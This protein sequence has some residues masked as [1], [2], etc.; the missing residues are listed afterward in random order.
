MAF[1]HDFARQRT[2]EWIQ[3]LK[4][5]T[6]FSAVEPHA[7]YSYAENGHKKLTYLLR[8]MDLEAEVL[9]P[10]GSYLSQSFVP[11]AVG[12]PALSA[13]D[14]RVFTLPIRHGRMA[15]LDLVPISV[16]QRWQSRHISEPGPE[17]CR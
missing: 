14:F 4:V 16:Q 1:C 10:M 2:Y 13:S 5:L 12:Q 7:A 6:D 3:E 11:V 8:A 9:A 17:H 15:I